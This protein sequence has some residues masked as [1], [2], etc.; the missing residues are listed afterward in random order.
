MFLLQY[1]RQSAEQINKCVYILPN[2]QLNHESVKCNLEMPM[3]MRLTDN[4]FILVLPI[5][6]QV[7]TSFLF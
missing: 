5:F 7:G 1:V 3:K 6:V 2:I 4:L